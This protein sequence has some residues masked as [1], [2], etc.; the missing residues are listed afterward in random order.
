MLDFLENSN[1]DPELIKKRLRMYGLRTYEFNRVLLIKSDQNIYSTP[2]ITYL[3]NILH[4]YAQSVI[5]ISYNGYLIMVLGSNKLFGQKG[6]TSQFKETLDKYNLYGCISAVFSDIAYLK[7]YYQ[8][9]VDCFTTSRLM[10]VKNNLVNFYD[11]SFNTLLYIAGNHINLKE[12]IHPFV[13]ILQQHDLDNGTDYL[14]TLR[15][16]VFKT[17]NLN[18]AAQELHIHRNTLAYRLEK[19]QDLLNIECIDQK[20]ISILYMS[21]SIFDMYNQSELAL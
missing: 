3:T 15:Q 1:E 10:C 5:P 12:Y 14:E 16:Y 17:G 19:I 13:T 20:L 2:L 4:D 8:Q 18:S 11:Y 6:D 21:F 7:H 9:V